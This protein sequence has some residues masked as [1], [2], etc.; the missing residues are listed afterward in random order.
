MA[1]GAIKFYVFEKGS[2]VP[3]EGATIT[4]VKNEEG[5]NRRTPQS[6]L[7][8]SSGMAEVAELETPSL[9]Y[10]MSYKLDVQPYSLWNITIKAPKYRKLTVINAQVL[11]GTVTIQ[12]FYLT[13][14]SVSNFDDIIEVLAHTMVGNY[15]PKIY[16]TSKPSIM[17][18]YAL[19]LEKQG[20]PDSIK[21][22][23]GDPEWNEAINY[24]VGYKDYIKNV[25]SS[26]IYGNWPKEAIKANAIAIISFAL[27]RLFTE[28]YRA[29][30]KKFHITSLQANDQKWIQGIGVTENV[31][32]VVDKVFSSCIW[33]PDYYFPLL[34][35]YKDGIKV[36]PPK[37]EMS[38]WGSKELAD[39]GKSAEEILKYY[40]GSDIKFCRMKIIGDLGESYPGHS[41]KLGSKEESVKSLKEY[42]NRISGN[43]PLIPKLTVNDNFDGDTQKAVKIFQGIFGLNKSGVVD[44]E[45]WYK[46]SD[47]YIGVISYPGKLLKL[48]SK[49]PSVKIIQNYLNK[50]SAKYKEIPQITS[51]S[52]F[53]P[54]TQ[55]A[56][57]IF[58]GI[59]GLDK[60]GDVD[61]A[62]WYK[63]SDVYIDVI[64]KIKIIKEDELECSN[65][66]KEF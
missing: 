38:Q 55:R 17:V 13:P 24:I 64:F 37:G 4:I 62:T 58:Q 2:Y 28:W 23:D 27:N 21:I 44:Y 50:I 40:Y 26:E 32:E 5:N 14:S 22:H 43:Y 9:E 1:K 29:K 53:G 41:L 47:I 46:I 34:A 30:G 65:S 48:G 45:T 7:T 57:K 12:K 49:N 39:Q 63:I 31:N 59:F 56:V 3:I 35:Q 19:S 51:D 6:V 20:I 61:R 18:P 60:S 10:S 42:L 33:V 11:P 54:N 15:E 16:E 66:I 36:K 52:I 25:V 8:N